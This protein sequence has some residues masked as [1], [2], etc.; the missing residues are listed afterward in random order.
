MIG[1]HIMRLM[2][3]KNKGIT[4]ATFLQIGCLVTIVVTLILFGITMIY[5]TLQAD[6]SLE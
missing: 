6:E 3:F 5:I 1:A 4:F 2:K